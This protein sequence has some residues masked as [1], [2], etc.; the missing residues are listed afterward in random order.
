VWRSYGEII[1][2]GQVLPRHDAIRIT[3]EKESMLPAIN[4]LDVFKRD[5]FKCVYCDY[6]GSKSFDAWLRGS[7]HVDHWVPRSRGGTDE[8]ENLRTA[9]GPCN[10]Y[11][12]N[13]TFPSL[14]PARLWLRIHREECFETWWET[15]VAGTASSWKPG[16]IRRTQER[17]ERELQALKPAQDRNWKLIAATPPDEEAA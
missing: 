1:E 8:I 5:D 17:Y 6:D 10:A 9:C 12:G 16:G 4:E 14:E 11:K 15:Y 13:R 3:T 7:F 2:A